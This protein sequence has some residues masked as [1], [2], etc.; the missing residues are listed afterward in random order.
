MFAPDKRKPN[1]RDHVV[2]LDGSV[3]RPPFSGAA[4][5]GDQIANTS[6]MSHARLLQSGGPKVLNQHRWRGRP[7][8]HT[9][10][11]ERAQTAELAAKVRAAFSP[12]VYIQIG[13]DAQRTVAKRLRSALQANGF[14]VPPSRTSRRSAVPAACLKCEAQGT[15]GGGRADESHHRPGHHGDEPRILSIANAKPAR[16]TMKSGSINRTC[17]HPQHRPAACSNNKCHST[18]RRQQETIRWWMAAL[19]RRQWLERVSVRHSAHLP[20]AHSARHP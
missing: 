14:E 3:P 9:C 10:G 7:N 18:L 8:A 12:L 13:S 4:H 11:T 1:R 6:G 5:A 15:S 20:P 16:D 17:V 2:V 19:S